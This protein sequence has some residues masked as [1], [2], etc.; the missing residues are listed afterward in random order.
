MSENEDTMHIEEEK[1]DILRQLAEL[2][3]DADDM[4]EMDAADFKDNAGKIWKLRQR[5]RDVLCV[6]EDKEGW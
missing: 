2:F 4:S 1:E 5:A 6:D 3:G